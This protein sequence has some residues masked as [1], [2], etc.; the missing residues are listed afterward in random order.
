VTGRWRPLWLERGAP[1]VFPDPRGADAVGLCAVGGDLSVERLVFAYSNGIFPWFDESEPPC[2]WSPD[3]RC[4]FTPD[5][6]HVPR[7]LARRIRRGGFELTWNRAFADV[8]R[9]C[10]EREQGSWIFAEMLDAYAA[11]HDAGHAHSLE[12]WADG[13]LAAGIYGVQVGRLFAAES[14]FHRVRDL[15][16][17]ALVACVRSLFAAGIELFDV[18][19]PT[20]HLMSLGAAEWPRWRYLEALRRVVERECDL[21]GLDP[22]TGL[23]TTK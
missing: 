9:A 13:E 21:R 15:S 10:G 7:R 4:V 23:T 20:P 3:P 8:M 16:K 1:L 18:Q 11:L 6:L 22:T 17:V 2:W 14:K 5:G 19:M 12:V